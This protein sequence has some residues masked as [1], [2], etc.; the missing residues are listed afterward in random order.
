LPPT[1]IA[2]FRATLEEISE[3]D[4]LIHVVDLTSH[5]AA[6]QCDIVEDILAELNLTEKPRITVLNKI[7]LLLSGSQKWD[8]AAALENI[9]EECGIPG[10]NTV[11]V[12]AVKKWGFDKLKEL[13][14]RLLVS[15]PVPE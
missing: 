15:S 3:A 12:S 1:L 8:E 9:A 14:S 7:D 4:L 11:L 6:E 13:I 5:N 2:A 10:P